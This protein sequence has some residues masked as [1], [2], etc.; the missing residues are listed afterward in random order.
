MNSPNIF[1]YHEKN[2]S[3]FWKRVMWA[4]QAARM[5]YRWQ[6]GNGKQVSFWEDQWFGTCSLAIQFWRVYVLVNE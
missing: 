3:P 4:A 6:I 2:S 1:C 5:S